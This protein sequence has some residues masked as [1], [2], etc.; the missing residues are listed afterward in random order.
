MVDIAMLRIVYLELRV[1]FLEAERARNLRDRQ[2]YDF[3]RIAELDAMPAP[4]IELDGVEL[5][6]VADQRREPEGRLLAVAGDPFPSRCKQMRY[7]ELPVEF[8]VVEV[9]ASVRG[10]LA[11]FHEPFDGSSCR[12]IVGFQGASS[13][14]PNSRP[15]QVV[16]RRFEI[17]REVLHII[18]QPICR[19]C[20]P[21]CRRGLPAHRCTRCSEARL[22]T[23]RTP[24]ACP[25]WTSSWIRSSSRSAL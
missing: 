25:R 12:Y 2:R 18:A 20:S 13:P 11:P 21:S 3:Q 15:G 22:R 1:L 9:H 14:R 24:S 4:E 5:V 16:C 19:G 6:H 7:D 17:G 23:R 8:Q 10:S